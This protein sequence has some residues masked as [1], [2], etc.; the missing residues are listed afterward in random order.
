MGSARRK[1]IEKTTARARSQN[2]LL[3]AVRSLNK[4]ITPVREEFFQTRSTNYNIEKSRE[5]L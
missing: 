2:V 5:R 3:A 4:C 1:E